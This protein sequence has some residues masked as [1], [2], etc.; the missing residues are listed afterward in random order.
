MYKLCKTEQSATRQHQLEEGLLA[1]ICTHRY[2]ELSV[3]DLC[4][5]LNIPRKSFYRYFSSKEGALHA[6]LDHTLMRF[7]GFYAPSPEQK[8]SLHRDLCQ[9]FLF[10][11]SQKPLLDALEKNDLSGLLIQ[12]SIAYALSDTA[13]PRRFLPKDDPATQEQ[14]VMFAVCGLMSMVI[15]WHRDGFVRSIPQM[16]DLAVRVLTQPLFP[17]IS[18]FL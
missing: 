13:M 10:W 9:F 1:A 8:R 14:V 11:Q 5:Q 16:A 12:R 2:D 3:S 18:N 15:T 4:T 17:D 6:L 7:E